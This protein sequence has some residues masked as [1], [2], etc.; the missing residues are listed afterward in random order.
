MLAQDERGLAEGFAPDTLA[1]NVPSG[2][3]FTPRVMAA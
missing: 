3:S 1:H 2:R